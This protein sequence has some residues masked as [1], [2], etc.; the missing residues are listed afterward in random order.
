[1]GRSS[2]RRSSLLR[3]LL[4]YQRTFRQRLQ[5]LNRPIEEWTGALDA[6]LAVI[7]RRCGE[8]DWQKAAA[9]TAV[10]RSCGVISAAGTGKTST[11]SRSWRSCSR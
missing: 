1:L 7:S 11:W 10:R 4:D 6:E 5:A 2:R 9:A 8:A 3:A